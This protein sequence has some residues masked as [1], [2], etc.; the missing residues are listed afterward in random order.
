MGSTYVHKAGGSV[1]YGLGT[2][3]GQWLVRKGVMLPRTGGR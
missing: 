2:G 3:P 1:E